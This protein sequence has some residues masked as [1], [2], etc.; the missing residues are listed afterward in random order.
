MKLLLA[1]LVVASLAVDIDAKCGGEK[2][3]S[4]VKTYKIDL[5]L[6]PKDRFKQ[7]TN[8]FKEP[9]NEWLQAEK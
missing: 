9:M 2:T 3:V 8:D 7:V 6:A 5:D 4:Q 1:L